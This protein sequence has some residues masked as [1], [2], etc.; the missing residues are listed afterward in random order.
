MFVV[1]TYLCSDRLFSYFFR[2]LDFQ[3]TLSK[4]LSVGIKIT[5]SLIFPEC[6]FFNLLYQ[7]PEDIINFLFLPAWDFSK[8]W[9][10]I[11]RTSDIS[12]SMPVGKNYQGRLFILTQGPDEIEASLIFLDQTFTGSITF[13][14][15][16]SCT[17]IIS[18]SY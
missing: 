10:S 16:A 1:S 12:D 13:W 6:F 2:I 8:P 11:I 15:P 17:G 7:I 4:T 14:D 18:N 9:G 5:W 3:F